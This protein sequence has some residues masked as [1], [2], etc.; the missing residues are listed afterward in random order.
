MFWYI[1]ETFEEAELNVAKAI[2][3]DIGT[4]IDDDECCGE[5]N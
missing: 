3:S 4:K 1:L 2:Q 5:A